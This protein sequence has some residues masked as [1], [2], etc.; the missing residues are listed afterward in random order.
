MEVFIKPFEFRQSVIVHKSTGKRARDLRELRDMIAIVSDES[1]FHHTYQ[2]FLKGH[3]LEYTSDFS[4][5]VGENLEEAALSEL[6]SNIDP[7]GFRSVGDLREE[8]LNVIDRY[9]ESFP[10]PRETLPGEEFYFVETIRLIFP[11]GVK[12]K[13][14]AEFLI[15]AKYID[16]ASIYYH[17]YEARTRL[18]S[19]VDDFSKWF[20]DALGKPELAEKVRSI[21]PFMHNIEGIRLHLEE[22]IDEEV[23]RDMETLE[24]ES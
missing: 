19:G 24:T 13:N 3:I 15:A 14:L 17:F 1:I 2:Y 4:Q 12:V 5:W 8:I 22:Y 11:I 9:L 23:R 20:E 6:L 21:D 10:E 16:N 18:G 7:Y